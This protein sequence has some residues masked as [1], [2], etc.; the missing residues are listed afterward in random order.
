MKKMLLLATIPFL[1]S[2]CSYLNQ[3]LGLKDDNIA[4]EV[5]EDVIEGRTGIDVDLTPS[6]SEKK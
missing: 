1:F 3:K 4:E 5:F 6:S 2:G